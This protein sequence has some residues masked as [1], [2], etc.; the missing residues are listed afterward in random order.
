MDT[1]QIENHDFTLG[2]W[3]VEP[4]LNR[5]RRNGETIRLRPQAMDVLVCLSKHAGRVVTKEELVR[6]VW[7]GR[8]VSESSL[9]RCVVELRR[10]LHD[11]AQDSQVIETVQKRGYRVLLPVTPASEEA[12]LTRPAND[13]GAA[14]AD[15]PAAEAMEPPVGD[16]VPAEAPALAADH[17]GQAASASQEALDETGGFHLAPML[18]AVS[19]L[20]LILVGVANCHPW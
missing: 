1:E 17:P 13:P 11:R 7:G 10:H 9:A 15:E 2:D 16:G 20:I 19:V 18:A 3:R 14:G 4:S 12:L 5:L 6:N 8:F